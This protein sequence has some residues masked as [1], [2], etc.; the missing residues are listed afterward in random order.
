MVPQHGVAMFRVHVTGPKIE[1]WLFLDEKYAKK[2]AK[3]QGKIEMMAGCPTYC[4]Y[5]EGPCH[6]LKKRKWLFLDEKYTKIEMR[7]GFLTKNEKNI[8]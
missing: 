1:T 8:E 7:M 4:G 2:I 5:A 3:K 6:I